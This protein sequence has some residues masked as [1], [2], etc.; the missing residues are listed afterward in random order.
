MDNEALK[1]LVL[2]GSQMI[3]SAVQVVVAVSGMSQCPIYIVTMIFA[4]VMILQAG[5]EAY[6][7]FAVWG[8]R[9]FVQDGLQVPDWV[10]RFI[11]DCIKSYV[12]AN[13]L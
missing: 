2:C 8:L 10:D 11:P 1:N 4:F 3:L 7:W 9:R 5:E 6:I 12:K 13:P